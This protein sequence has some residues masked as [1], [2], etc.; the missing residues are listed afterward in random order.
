MYDCGRLIFPLRLVNM[1]LL[2]DLLRERILY[3]DPPY[4]LS[5]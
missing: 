4:R 2:K 3:I 1:V 5:R